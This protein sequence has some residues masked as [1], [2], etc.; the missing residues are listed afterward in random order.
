MNLG[1][2]FFWHLIVVGVLCEEGAIFSLL[3]F[4]V[5]KFP[6][7]H[8]FLEFELRTLLCGIDK[9]DFTFQLFQ[10]CSNNSFVFDW[11]E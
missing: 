10:D 9:S 2:L 3:R 7:V 1:F 6:L 5:Q 11:V 8:A 4:L